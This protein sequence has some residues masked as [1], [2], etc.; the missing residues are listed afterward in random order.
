MFVLIERTESALDELEELILREGDRAR[1]LDLMEE[2][3]GC[4]I[5]I[6]S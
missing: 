1:V 2:I 5:S 3:K 4:L 6:L